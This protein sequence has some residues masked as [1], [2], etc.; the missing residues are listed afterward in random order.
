MLHAVPANYHAPDME[1]VEDDDDTGH[2]AGAGTRDQP[3]FF[4][5]D[6]D[7]PASSPVS[8]P[9]TPPPFGPRMQSTPASRNPP[10]SSRQRLKPKGILLGTWS[11]SGLHA[12]QSNAVYGSR[13]IKDRINR[14]IAK[15]DMAGSVVL[16]GRYDVKRTA[17]SHGDI[18]YV[19][20]YRG[21]S[22]DEV[23]S[24]IM[25]LLRA[26]DEGVR[27][28]SVSPAAAAASRRRTHKEETASRSQPGS[29]MRGASFFV[30]EASTSYRLH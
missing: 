22:K 21:M 1:E 8:R 17:C 19:V 10:S 12:D 29:S 15:V 20:R 4:D 24:V 13:D 5:S 6:D 25:P 30:D 23:D 9:T 11:K 16:G 27:D 14:R 18:N 7:E 2:T 26:A 28:R 3:F